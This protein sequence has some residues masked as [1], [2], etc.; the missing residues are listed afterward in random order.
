MPVF[1]VLVTRE[2]YSHMTGILTLVFLNE[3]HCLSSGP[4]LLLIV[5][6][7][8]LLL[9]SDGLLKWPLTPAGLKTSCCV[10]LFILRILSCP[11]LT[12]NTLFCFPIMI[13]VGH[14]SSGRM[15]TLHAL[16]PPTKSL[17]QPPDVTFIVGISHGG[18]SLIW[19][20]ISM[21]TTITSV[22]MG[23]FSP[24]PG[25]HILHILQYTILLKSETDQKQDASPCCIVWKFQ[26]S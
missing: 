3:A 26:E 17:S 6:Y 23:K 12:T 13:S 19:I 1:F 7:Q 10:Q 25:I 18:I 8:P 11:I 2:C 5:F 24:F 16:Y 20:I 21:L 22:H 9:P 15:C 14:K 4:P